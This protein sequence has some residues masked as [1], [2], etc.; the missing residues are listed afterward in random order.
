LIRLEYRGKVSQSST[1]KF[2]EWGSFA[3]VSGKA[4][5][6]ALAHACAVW[7]KR[8][9]E[10]S[11]LDLL[12]PKGRKRLAVNLR[13]AAYH[14]PY[15]VCIDDALWGAFIWQAFREDLASAQAWEE[16]LLNISA[17]LASA[18]R[19]RTKESRVH[20]A[21]AKRAEQLS[22]AECVWPP[23]IT[24]LVV[25]SENRELIYLVAG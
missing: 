21:Y 15:Y 23:S 4:N 10:D 24:S 14:W 2:L 7:R 1:L 20:E 16:D 6:T 19:R 18:S 11:T 22:V 3:P 13:E 8:S 9:E 5:G 25:R 12:R 17:E